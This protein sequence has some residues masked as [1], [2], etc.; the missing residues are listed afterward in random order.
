MNT[1]KNTILITGGGTGIGFALAKGFSDLGNT[2]VICGRRA[3]RLQAAKEALSGIHTFECDIS[4]KE[5]C[6]RLYESVSKEFGGINVLVNNAGIQ[7]R[8]DLKKGVSEL[9]EKGGEIASNLES[10]INLS[11]YFIPDL[12]KRDEAAIMNVSSGLGFIP[13]ARFPIYCATKAAIHSFST[14]LRYQLKDTSVKVF[15]M[16]L[17]TVKDTELKSAGGEPDVQ[18]G[19]TSD[20]VVKAMLEAFKSDTY[21]AYIG[22]AETLAKKSRTEPDKAFKEMNDRIPI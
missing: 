11:A 1:E 21:E 2:V 13:I 9:L 20:V 8:M 4:S 12:M 16:V 5:G 22:E 19:T 7:R 10:V 15:E 6:K 18:F 17:P 14:S 3:D